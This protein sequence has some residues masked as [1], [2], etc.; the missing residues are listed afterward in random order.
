MSEDLPK[1]AQVIYDTLFSALKNGT[2]MSEAFFDENLNSL[3]VIGA[4]LEACRSYGLDVSSWWVSLSTHSFPLSQKDM[5]ASSLRYRSN[6]IL[7]VE[8]VYFTIDF[9]QGNQYV[10]PVVM[11]SLD[12]YIQRQKDSFFQSCGENIHVNIEKNTQDGSVNSHLRGWVIND[13]AEAM[14]SPLAQYRRERLGSLAA[15]DFSKV[16]SKPPLF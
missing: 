14:K 1:G 2:E 6:L 12:E 4:T 5:N 8:G 7:E 3:S 11:S 10:G 15:N 13:I 16:R 9:I